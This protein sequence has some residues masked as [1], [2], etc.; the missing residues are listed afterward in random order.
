MYLHIFGDFLGLTVLPEESS[1]N[2]LSAHPEH[3][4]WHSRILGT[5]SLS[6]TAVT[7]LSLGLVVFLASVARVHV[8]L[9]PHDKSI[10]LEFPYIL[11][12][13]GQCDFTCLVR[14]NPHSLLSTLQHSSSQPLL[15]SQEC[16]RF[17]LIINNDYS[18]TNSKLFPYSPNILSFPQ[19]VLSASTLL[20]APHVGPR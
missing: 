17:F 10:L 8:Y 16:H 4:N 14:V 11:A 20:P 18:L 6:V 3:L 2:T 5:F 19:L 12:R 13:V 9:A 1:E 15:E 7:S